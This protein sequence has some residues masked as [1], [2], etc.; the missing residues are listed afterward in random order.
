MTLPTW[1]R[2][3]CDRVRPSTSVAGV[4]TMKSWPTCWR[5]LIR[6]NARCAGGTGG[7][8]AELA[9]RTAE[10]TTDGT[11]TRVTVPGAPDASRRRVELQTTVC[12]DLFA[13]VRWRGGPDLD[14]PVAPAD[15]GPHPPGAGADPR[16]A[17]HRRA[18]HGDHAR[19][20]PGAQHRRDV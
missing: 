7:A 9:S 10:R 4:P 17:A 11:S 19:R 1:N 6:S 14:H 8:A 13:V 15:E 16:H 12:K 18:G 2:P 3:I 5:R 20:P